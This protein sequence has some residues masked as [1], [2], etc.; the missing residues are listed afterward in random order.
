MQGVSCFKC[1][2][3]QCDCVMRCLL[4]GGESTFSGLFIASDYLCEAEANMV[5]K[6]RIYNSCVCR[7]GK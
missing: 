6:I 5:I 1:P 4:L 7:V 3:C 2:F